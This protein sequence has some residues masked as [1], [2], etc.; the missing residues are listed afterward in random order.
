MVGREDKENVECVCDG[1]MN[2]CQM[3]GG[4]GFQTSTLEIKKYRLKAK[5]C[6]RW[7]QNHPIFFTW[8][9]LFLVTKIHDM[10]IPKIT[11]R[12]I[13]VLDINAPWS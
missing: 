7:E 6:E 5:S 13:N 11:L 1:C 2:G 9:Q 8:P 4:R 10:V 12:K 3:M